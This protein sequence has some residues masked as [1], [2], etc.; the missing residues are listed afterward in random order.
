MLYPR[1]Y[2]H[3]GV[4]IV[5]AE[6]ARD[7]TMVYSVGIDNS[8][9][10]WDATTGEQRWSRTFEPGESYAVR[11]LQVSPSGELLLL[12]V[13]T[14]YQVVTSTDATTVTTFESSDDAPWIEKVRWGKTDSMFIKSDSYGGMAILNAPN[15]TLSSEGDLEVEATENLGRQL[16]RVVFGANP[17]EPIIAWVNAQQVR[18]VSFHE[19]DRSQL[20]ESYSHGEISHWNPQ[21]TAYLDHVYTEVFQIVQVTRPPRASVSHS[22]SVTPGVAA[23]R[24]TPATKMLPLT[25]FWSNDGRQVGFVFDDF[26]EWHDLDGKHLSSLSLHL[27]G[28]KPPSARYEDGESDTAVRLS[29]DGSKLLLFWDSLGIV[30]LAAGRLICETGRHSVPIETLEW[31]EQDSKIS[32]GPLYTHLHGESVAIDSPNRADGLVVPAAVAQYSSGDLPSNEQ[33]NSFHN[34]RYRVLGDGTDVFI[35]TTRASKKLFRLDMNGP[36]CAVLWTEDDQRVAVGTLDKV[37]VFDVP[38]QGRRR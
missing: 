26:I 33:S 15:E 18:I 30:D 2:E 21:A 27:D 16:Q 8:L 23:F 28:R 20:P 10:A 11:D 6:W 12:R 5:C 34:N 19:H 25:A 14:D 36:I 38:Q 35:V 32:Y 31:I 1:T 17:L 37:L 4:P 9:K 29:P 3:N 22:V 24:Q 7:G 13:G